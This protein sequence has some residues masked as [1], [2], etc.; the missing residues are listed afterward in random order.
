MA[1]PVGPLVPLD[2]IE[3]PRRRVASP[4]I[5]FQESPVHAD[6]AFGSFGTCLRSWPS[7]MVAP[8]SGARI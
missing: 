4:L 3:A 1:L 5:L 8:H 6:R 7:A 2:D